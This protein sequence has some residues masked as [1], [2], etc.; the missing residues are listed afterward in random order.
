MLCDR[1]TWTRTVDAAAAAGFT[2]LVVDLAEGV[3]YDSHPELALPGSWTT[4]EL[5]E[6]LAR[7]RELGL[8]PVPKLNFSAAHDTWLGEYGWQLSTPTWYRVTTELITEVAELFDS[9][10]LFHLGM[11][12]ETDIAQAHYDFSV[13]RRRNRWWTDL[14]HLLGVVRGLGSRPWVWADPAWSDPHEYYARMPK[15]VLQS[16][17]YYGQW[18]RSG[19]APRPRVLTGDHFLAYLDL[20]DHGYDQVPTG[21]SWKNN[22]DNFDYTVDYATEH[23]APERLLGFLQ[24]TWALTTPD[25]LDRH[26][27]TI[28]RAAR[29]IERM[30]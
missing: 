25:Q 14:E 13:V 4:G 11:D 17:W 21:S 8:T 20:E 24:T 9:P 27:E 15:D 5:R 16:N 2:H 7:L 28:A 29:T 3:R 26:L 18:F 6:E 10:A 30:R 1:V 23:V 19:D 22:W 12:E